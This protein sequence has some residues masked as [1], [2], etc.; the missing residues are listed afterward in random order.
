MNNFYTV[1]YSETSKGWPSFFSYG[2]EQ[3][4]GMNN[5]FYSFKG[6]RLYRHNSSGVGRGTFY[7]TQ[8]ASTISTVFNEAPLPTP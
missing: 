1:S 7:G 5:Y 2:P 8:S 4:V 3:M 6:G